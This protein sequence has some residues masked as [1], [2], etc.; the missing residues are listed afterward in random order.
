MIVYKWGGYDWVCGSPKETPGGEQHNLFHLKNYEIPKLKEPTISKKLLW[1]SSH[2][3]FTT[4]LELA[5]FA[6]IVP[7]I[8]LKL[9]G[10]FGAI[11]S[12]AVHA[13]S[14]AAIAWGPSW[15]IGHATPPILSSRMEKFVWLNWVECWCENMAYTLQPTSFSLL[16]SLPMLSVHLNLVPKCGTR[17]CSS[18]FVLCSTQGA[19]ARL[20]DNG[21]LKGESLLSL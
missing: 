9:E 13:A 3:N 10:N 18:T 20:H 19:P 17:A 8:H 12:E 21:G 14:D 5:E 7:A 11:R 2:A 6:K 1:S 4:P 16:H 15:W